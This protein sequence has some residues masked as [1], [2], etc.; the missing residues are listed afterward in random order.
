MG[1]D[2]LEFPE[3]KEIMQFCFLTFSRLSHNV[4]LNQQEDHSADNKRPLFLKMYLFYR[5]G[6][7]RG[8]GRGREKF[9]QTP[10]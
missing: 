10:Q 8:R 4:P 5:V 6:E 9:K 1:D 7:H 2:E 3:N